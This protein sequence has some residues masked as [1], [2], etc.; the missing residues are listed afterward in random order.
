MSEVVGAARRES[1]PAV[2]RD[3][4]RAAVEQSPA[5]AQ[6]DGGAAR[7]AGVDQVQFDWEWLARLRRP[8]N[9]IN[10]AGLVAGGILAI[11]AAFT[12]AN[13]I[14]LTMMLYREEIEI[15]RL[16]GATERIIRGPFLVE[17]F[18]QGTIGGIVAVV[19]SSRSSSRRAARCRRELA[20]LELPLHRLPAV[21][22]DRRADRRRHARRLVRQLALGAGVGRGESTVILR[23][24]EAGARSAERRRTPKDLKI[25]QPALN[26][27]V[28]AGVAH[29]EI[30]R[31]P[32]ALAFALHASGGSG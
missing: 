18:L 2:V 30:L 16:V 28:S 6:R 5:F 8:I 9:M 32:A 27:R 7:L 19:C 25:P 31:R 29:L 11:A 23:L 21:A 22:E 26:P 15:M 14:R 1:V 12:I 17:G 3:R 4:G 24:P 10:I 13:V 20:D